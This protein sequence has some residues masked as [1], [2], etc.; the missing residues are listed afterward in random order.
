[1]IIAVHIGKGELV[2]D[3]RFTSLLDE[4]RDGGCVVKVLEPG[5]YPSQDAEMLLSVGGDGT[6]LSSSVLAAC[7]LYTSPSPRD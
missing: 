3:V 7:L 4:L 6:F 2:S 5:E 1:M